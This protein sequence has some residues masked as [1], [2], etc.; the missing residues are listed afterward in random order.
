MMHD[1]QNVLEHA[2]TA[3]QKNDVSALLKLS[4]EAAYSASRCHQ[5]LGDL[6]REKKLFEDAAQAY[7]NCAATNAS[8]IYGEIECWKNLKDRAAFGDAVARYL[9]LEGGNLVLLSRIFLA[10]AEIEETD[11]ATT[12][13]ETICAVPEAAD[14]RTAF[15]IAKALLLIGE[16]DRAQP[17]AAQAKA[18]AGED[19]VLLLEIAT[20]NYDL[21]EYWEQRYNTSQGER[22]PVPVADQSD[23]AYRIRRDRDIQFLDRVFDQ[24]FAETQF[25]TMADCGCGS[26][27]LTPCIAARATHLDSFDI[28]PTAI[29]YAQANNPDLAHVKFQVANLAETPLDAQAYDLVFDFTAVQHVADPVLWK[30]VLE[31]Y[32]RAVKP[33]GYLF[34]VQYGGN[35]TDRQVFHVNNASI[36]TYISTLEAMGCVLI[37]R[38]ISPTPDNP[39]EE[40]IVFRI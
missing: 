39:T 2:Q 37:H 33:G 34:L 30:T 26:G 31:N 12:V 25:D 23:A 28:S 13:F 36:D 18:G 40:C 10:A 32:V 19:E 4:R 8:A 5:L 3:R 16:K 38:E 27:R 6:Y 7:Q 15:R 17:Y 21:N 22:T 14:A 11:L 29:G 9:A 35:D 1:L 24:L 20:L